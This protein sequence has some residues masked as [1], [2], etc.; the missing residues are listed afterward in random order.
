MV[1]EARATHHPN[2]I[3]ITE[4]QLNHVKDREK[5][6][7][8]NLPVSDF[9]FETQTV[10]DW[11]KKMH[12]YIPHLPALHDNINLNLIGRFYTQLIDYLV[13]PKID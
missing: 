1:K 8:L 5:I 13:N 4:K 7:D 2:L 10:T 11:Y 3:K 12:N 6:L 9:D